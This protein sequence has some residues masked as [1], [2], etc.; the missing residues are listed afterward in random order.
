MAR[1][2]VALMLASAALVCASSAHAVVTVSVGDGTANADGS[3]TV[4]VTVACT[5]GS[6]VIEALVTL[7]QD[8]GAVWAMAGIP[9]VRCTG[10]PRTYLVTLRP[11]DAAFHPGTAYASPYVLV[12]SRR[13]GETESGGS[14]RYI[15][16]A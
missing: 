14:A 7:S 5:P 10:Q 1:S 15:T 9:N 3:A 4:P 13:T 8:D 11:Y 12:Q 16:L 6:V 2:L